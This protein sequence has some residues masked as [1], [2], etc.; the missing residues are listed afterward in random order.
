VLVGALRGGLDASLIASKKCCAL[1]PYGR[2]DFLIALSIRADNATLTPDP[3]DQKVRLLLG[4]HRGRHG[5]RP[6]TRSESR[7]STPRC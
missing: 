5:P 1:G 4:E 6:S 3:E 7:A 2:D